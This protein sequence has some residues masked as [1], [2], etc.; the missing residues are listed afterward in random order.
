[1][2][3]AVCSTLLLVAYVFEASVFDRYVLLT[4]VLNPFRDCSNA[5]FFARLSDLV[6]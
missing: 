3:V 6:S 4:L 2:L 1:M 5:V